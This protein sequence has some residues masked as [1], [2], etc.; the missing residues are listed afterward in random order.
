MNALDRLLVRLRLLPK[1][2]ITVG[3]APRLAP[4]HLDINPRIPAEM[5][6]HCAHCDGDCT[7][8]HTVP[9]ETCQRDAS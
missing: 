1:P 3:L 4:Y 6:D 8:L 2:R 5:W 9:C 7:Y